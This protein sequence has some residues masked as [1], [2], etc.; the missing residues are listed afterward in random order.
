MKIQDRFG[1]HLPTEPAIVWLIHHRAVVQTLNYRVEAKMNHTCP[2]KQQASGPDVV[3]S[4][5][6]KRIGWIIA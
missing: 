1:L 3:H 4:K 2:A 5:Y 6:Y